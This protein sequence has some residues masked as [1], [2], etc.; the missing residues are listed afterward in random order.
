MSLFHEANRPFWD[1]LRKFLVYLLIELDKAYG[2]RTVIPDAK[3]RKAY[4]ESRFVSFTVNGKEYEE[5]INE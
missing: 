2:W 1:A 4:F 3:E 5:Y